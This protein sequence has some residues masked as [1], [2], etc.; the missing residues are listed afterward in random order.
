MTSADWPFEG[1]ST[2]GGL[3][4]GKRQNLEYRADRNERQQEGRPRVMVGDALSE[5]E[6]EEGRSADD[7][8]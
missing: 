4:D 2:S 8:G 7:D 3:A 1:R 6:F 5:Y